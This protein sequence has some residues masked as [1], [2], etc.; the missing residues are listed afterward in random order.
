MRRSKRRT[1]L[2][3]VYMCELNTI[4]VILSCQPHAAFTVCLIELCLIWISCCIVQVCLCGSSPNVFKTKKIVRIRFEEV[5]K[6][7]A[8]H[9][10]WYLIDCIYILILFGL[11]VSERAN[12]CGFKIYS[13]FGIWMFA[14]MRIEKLNAPLAAVV[15]S[16]CFQHSTTKIKPVLRARF[17]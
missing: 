15:L 13:C 9:I 11:G 12:V 17:T 4:V 3:F 2:L 6:K 7:T 10:A 16:L 1:H 14:L 8:N 5:E